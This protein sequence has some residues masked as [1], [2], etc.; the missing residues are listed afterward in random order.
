M[1]IRD[2]IVETTT[3]V[4]DAVC[5]LVEGGGASLDLLVDALQ[6]VE[7]S[8]QLSYFHLVAWSSVT[9]ALLAAPGIPQIAF[10]S[11]M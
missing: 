6:Q 5:Q 11:A 10:F 7:P 3:N 9:L 8:Q 2:L 4:G 1:Q